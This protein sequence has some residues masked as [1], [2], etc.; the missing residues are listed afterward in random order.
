[1]DLRWFHDFKLAHGKKE[2]VPTITAAIDAFNITNTTNY[3][4]FVG[5]L[6]S[7]FFADLC[8]RSISDDC[9]SR[10]E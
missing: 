10:P 8:R 2:A 6:S 7:T 1:M 5:N 4:S 3:P 9:N